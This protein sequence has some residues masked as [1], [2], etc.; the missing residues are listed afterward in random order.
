MSEEENDSETHVEKIEI[1]ADIEKVEPEELEETPK[2]SKEKLRKA[3]LLDE[4]NAEVSVERELPKRRAPTANIPDKSKLGE[5]LT[6]KLDKK[7]DAVNLKVYQGEKLEETG[8]GND[9]CIHD[10]NEKRVDEISYTFFDP[11]PLKGKTLNGL[12]KG[13][14]L[15]VVHAY[16]Q[17]AGDELEQEQIV[18]VQ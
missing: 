8:G 14:Y 13:K 11:V 2:V 1:G 16:G 17:E 10:K 4:I 7:Y 15:V 18:D 6:V 3:Q 12:T 9:N 5:Q